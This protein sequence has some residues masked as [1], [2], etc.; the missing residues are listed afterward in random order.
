MSRIAANKTT[1]KTQPTKK[2]GLTHDEIE[3]IRQA[4]ELF[5]T[6]NTGKI[7]PKELKAAMQSLGFDQK[8][9]TIYQL[10]ADLDTVEAA[11]RGGVDFESFTNAINEKLGDKET[12]DG[13]RRIFTLFIDDPYSESININSLKKIAKELGE[14][15]S[16]EELQDML[17]RASQS[18]NELTFSEFYDIMTKKSFP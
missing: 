6:N 9:P 11:K 5:D 4:F 3:E 7:D 10:V 18:G 8:N 1:A 12:K 13:I 14:N 17:A 16:P 15:M 2:S